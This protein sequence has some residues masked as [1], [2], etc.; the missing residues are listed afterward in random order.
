MFGLIALPELLMIIVGILLF[1]FY[2]LGYG[3]GY[4]K[5]REQA[6]RERARII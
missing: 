4:R 6:D 2:R 3:S 1:V 5:A